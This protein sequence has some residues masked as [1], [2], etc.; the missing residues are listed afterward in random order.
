MF[1]VSFGELLMVHSSLAYVPTHLDIF[2]EKML[3]STVKLLQ[4][5]WLA[6]KKEK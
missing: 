6:R 1:V 4:N 2:T 5:Y 3:V